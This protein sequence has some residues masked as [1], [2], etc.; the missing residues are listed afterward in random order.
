MWA[1][2]IAV[3]SV[4]MMSLP[5]APMHL[6]MPHNNGIVGLEVPVCDGIS[7]SVAWTS[8]TDLFLF[9]GVAATIILMGFAASEAMA[10]QHY[11]MLC[12]IISPALGP[13]C[14]VRPRPSDD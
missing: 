9:V 3:A 12:Y 8:G 4:F 7:C 1:P 5:V 10:T 13:K 14:L 11:P 2:R 6:P